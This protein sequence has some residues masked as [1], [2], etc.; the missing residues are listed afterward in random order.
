MATDIVVILPTIVNLRASTVLETVPARSW[1][2]VIHADSNLVV[3][4]ARP[5]SVVPQRY[6]S[7]MCD[8]RG[9]EA[10]SHGSGLLWSH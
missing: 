1:A 4:V 3:R 9:L 5:Q 2:M 10:E 8:G 7:A 6:V